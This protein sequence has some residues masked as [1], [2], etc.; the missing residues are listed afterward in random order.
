MEISY[1][2]YGESIYSPLL[3]T[4]VLELLSHL[5]KIRAEKIHW[6][7]LISPLD[8]FSRREKLTRFKSEV[9]RHGILF[10]YYPIPILYSRWF[11]PRLWVMPFLLLVGVFFLKFHFLIHGR[12]S[13]IHARGYMAAMLATIYKRQNSQVAVLFDPRSLFPEENITAG[14]WSQRSVNYRMWKRLEFYILRNVDALVGVSNSFQ[15]LA[16][17]LKA[18]PRL[19][20]KTVP[21]SVDINKF[22]KSESENR[23]KIL[24]R[25]NFPEDSFIF[26]YAGSIG[27]WNSPIMISKYFN[28]AWKT[29]EQCR[30]LVITNSRKHVV[31]STLQK[32]D[33]PDSV[34]RVI[35]VHSDEISQY[36][37]IG[38]VGLQVMEP[39]LDSATRLG[40]KFAEY[41]ASGLPVMVNSNVGGALEYV[42]SYRVGVV[43]DDLE[44]EMIFA[45]NTLREDGPVMK[46]RCIA[47]AREYFDI[48]RISQMYSE[49]YDS[50]I[51]SNAYS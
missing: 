28:S 5:S 49:L 37:K 9:K 15:R 4:Q 35:S 7:A 48:P 23:E 10:S 17:N 50:M 14:N 13:I 40:V 41:M 21:C 12:P 1:L 39:S 20:F 43:V 32:L 31:I 51:L 42:K 46:K 2:T 26:V 6:I 36:L 45:I 47:L 27:R 8:I 3:R 16:L 44:K 24:N 33:I 11:L 22:E 30:L 19:Q 29:F 38:N 34:Y 18:N 25:L